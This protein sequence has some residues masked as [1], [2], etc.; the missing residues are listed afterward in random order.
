MSRDGKIECGMKISS[1][2]EIT[3]RINL[4]R[5]DWDQRNAQNKT[6]AD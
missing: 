1:D 6:R 5:Y 3:A 4:K 2:D